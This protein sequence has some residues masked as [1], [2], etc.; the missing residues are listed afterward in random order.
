MDISKSIKNFIC[1]NV[2][3]ESTMANKVHDEITT[4]CKSERS[5][6]VVVSG[7][8]LSTIVFGYHHRLLL[9]VLVHH[10]TGEIE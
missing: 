3:H 10:A 6:G 2:Y 1:L 7:S 8:D 4:C 5:C 9:T